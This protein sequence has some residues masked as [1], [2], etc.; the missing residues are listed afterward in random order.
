MGK[1]VIW[2][3]LVLIGVHVLRWITFVVGP[4]FLYYKRWLNKRR[5]RS[6]MKR[7]LHERKIKAALLVATVETERGLIAERE[8]GGE[9][10]MIASNERN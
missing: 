2:L 8:R 4:I 5:A 10:N 7:R 9:K 3:T 6:A 1:S